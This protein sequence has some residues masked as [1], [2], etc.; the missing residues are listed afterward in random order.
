MTKET[1]LFRN[2]RDMRA[3]CVTDTI[4]AAH[5]GGYIH[6]DTLSN[7]HT[8]CTKDE[9]MARIDVYPDGSWQLEDGDIETDGINGAFLRL[10]FAAPDLYLDD[11]ED[12]TNQR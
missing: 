2:E 12:S 1:T 9:D 3:H 10:F 11:D 8:I 5:Q 7:G 6:F 4:E